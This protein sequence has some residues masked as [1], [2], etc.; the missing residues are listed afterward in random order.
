[1]HP[2]QGPKLELLKAREVREP[3]FLARN[4]LRALVCL[5]QTRL[6]TVWHEKA[7]HPCP[8]N[9]VGRRFLSR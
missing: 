6:L 2:L 7:R 5:G 3:R 1:M 8:G 4:L 9:G